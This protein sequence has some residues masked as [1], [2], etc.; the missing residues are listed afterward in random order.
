MDNSQ[1]MKQSKPR[2]KISTNLGLGLLFIT[3]GVLL[4]SRQMGADL[5]HWLFRWEMIVIAVGLAIGL[6]SRFRDFGWI[7]VMGVGLFFLVDDIFPDL[8]AS[9][10]FFPVAFV[11][12][13]VVILFNLFGRRNKNDR[14]DQPVQTNESGFIRMP[15][16]VEIPI[17]STPTNYTGAFAEEERVDIAAVFSGVNKKIFSKNFVG[18]EVVCVFGGSEVDLMNADI[19][20]GPIELEV[21]SIFGG[22]TLFLPSN[23][24]VKSELVSIFGGVDDKRKNPIPDPNKVIIIKG[25]FIFGGLEIKTRLR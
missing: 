17:V 7:P 1:T 10:Y 18:G 25:V 15:D 14:D 3:I 2:R 6:K 19:M 23:W 11:L 13:G 8:D 5:P 16:P 20:G 4:F 12:V 21:V 24:Y 22:A 9:R